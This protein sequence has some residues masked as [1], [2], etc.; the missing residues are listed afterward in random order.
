MVFSFSDAPAVTKSTLL[1][2]EIEVV[3]DIGTYRDVPAGFSNTKKTTLFAF[4]F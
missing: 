3:I 2:F 4:E 1:A